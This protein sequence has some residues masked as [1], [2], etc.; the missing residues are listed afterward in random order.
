M[1]T[2]ESSAAVSLFDDE[3][4]SCTQVIDQCG[5]KPQHEGTPLEQ[6]KMN[7]VGYWWTEPESDSS[8]KWQAAAKKLCPSILACIKYDRA[9][10]RP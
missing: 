9:G 2:K 3:A 10:H 1:W 7:I 6:Q 8:P 4:F 5:I